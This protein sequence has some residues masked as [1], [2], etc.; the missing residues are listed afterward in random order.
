VAAPPLAEISRADLMVAGA[1]FHRFAA[2]QRN[3]ANDIARRFA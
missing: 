1:I 3:K 2:V